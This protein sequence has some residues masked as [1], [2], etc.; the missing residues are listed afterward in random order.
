[1]GEVSSRIISLTTGG[2][3]RR[4]WKEVKKGK[5]IHIFTSYSIIVILEDVNAGEQTDCHKTLIQAKIHMHKLQ[6][7]RKYRNIWQAEIQICAETKILF[8]IRSLNSEMK[9]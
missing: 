4:G 5:Y 9:N 1:M 3:G 7:L 6:F 8:V 2:G